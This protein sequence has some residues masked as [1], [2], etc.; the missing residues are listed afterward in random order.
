MAHTVEGSGPPHGVLRCTRLMKLG[1][2]DRYAVSGHTSDPMFL[3]ASD[4]RRPVTVMQKT[5]ETAEGA[6]VH[7]LKLGLLIRQHGKCL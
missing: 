6:T 7:D 1:L 2:F 3:V 4:P 5:K